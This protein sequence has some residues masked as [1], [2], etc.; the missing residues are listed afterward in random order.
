MII[1]INIIS[2][3]FSDVCNSIRFLNHHHEVGAI[4]FTEAGCRYQGSILACSCCWLVLKL[5][6][7]FILINLT[8]SHI[9]LILRYVKCEMKVAGVFFFFFFYLHSSL[10]QLEKQCISSL[11]DLSFLKVLN[12]SILMYSVSGDRPPAKIPIPVPTSP[13]TNNEEV[14]EDSCFICAI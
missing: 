12:S 4:N 11:D 5:V 7:D 2:S 14:C 13:T 1:F 6:P 8:N 9:D 3:I 10:K